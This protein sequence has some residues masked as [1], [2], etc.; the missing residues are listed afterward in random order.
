MP[1]TGKV[2][3]ISIDMNNTSPNA[4]CTYLDDAVNISAGD[5][6]DRIDILGTLN[7]VCLET[8]W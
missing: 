7:H 2:Y 8:E 5:A 3:T 4:A 1:S 6:W